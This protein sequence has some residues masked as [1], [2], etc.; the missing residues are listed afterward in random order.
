MFKRL[1]KSAAVRTIEVTV[2][3]LIVLIFFSV[4]LTFLNFVF[5]LGTGMNAKDSRRGVNTQDSLMKMTV[6]D[7]LLMRGDSESGL[8]DTASLAGV[9]TSTDNS[10]KSKSARSIVWKEAEINMPLYNHDAVQTFQKSSAVITFDEGSSLRMGDNTLIIIRRIEQDNI[11]HEK[12]SFLVVVDGNLEGRF[13]GSQKK[14]MYVEVATPTAVARIRN[15]DRTGGQSD[16]KIAVNPDKSSTFTLLEGTAE[17][18]AKGRKVILKANQMTT[19]ALNMPPSAPESL[20]EPVKL[21]LPAPATFFYYRELPP[22]ISFSWEAR[23]G[24]TGYR[25]EIARDPYFEDIIDAEPSSTNRFIVGNLNQG[26]YYW[27]VQA[28]KA[29]GEGPYSRTRQFRII[30]D[31]KPPALSVDFPLGPVNTANLIISGQTEPGARVFVEGLPV[32]ISNEGAFE[33]AL[34]LKDGINTIVVEAVD[35]AGNVSYR[36]KFIDMKF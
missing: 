31:L 10:V 18:A 29:G 3:V 4:V 9:L 23:H 28:M 34:S 21:L 24:A 17:V 16:F 11:I 27:R 35:E 22:E 19:V 8:F 5:P 20:P 1:L 26:T 13:T 14:P 36:S 33:T 25:Y 6:R 12:R 2:A 30:Q 7:L 32:T 15:E